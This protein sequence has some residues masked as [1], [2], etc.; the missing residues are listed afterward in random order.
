YLV[1]KE[2]TL[3]INTSEKIFNFKFD[4]QIISLYSKNEISSMVEDMK[5]NKYSTRV[6]FEET[7]IIIDIYYRK[8]K[9]KRLN[10]IVDVLTDSLIKYDTYKWTKDKMEQFRKQE[11][12]EIKMKLVNKEK[13]LLKSYQLI[14]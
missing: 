4:E 14:F 9:K 5:K 2:L 3:D 12:K 13:A 8:Y 6:E 7:K 11:A 1:P 10:L